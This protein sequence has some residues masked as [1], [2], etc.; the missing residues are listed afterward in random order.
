MAKVTEIQCPA[1]GVES[2]AEM[3]DNPCVYFWDCPACRSVVRPKAGA[4]CAFC[5][6]GSAP[7]PLSAK[8]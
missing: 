6:Y 3:R 7:C 8:R 4:C 2:R 1:G 5:S